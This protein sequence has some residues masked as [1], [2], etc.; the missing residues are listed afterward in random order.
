MENILNL[1]IVAAGF[2]AGIYFGAKHYS[3]KKIQREDH[4]EL[5][6]KEKPKTMALSV[7]IFLAFW[8]GASIVGMATFV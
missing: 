8:F 3:Q 2:F 4:P 6:A 5:W 7:G 1:V